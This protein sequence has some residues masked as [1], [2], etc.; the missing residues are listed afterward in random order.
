MQRGQDWWDQWFLGLAAYVSTAS[1]DPS[2]QCG[3]V[4][5]D[6]NRRVVSIGFNGFPRGV[7]DDERLADRKTKY[8]IVVHSE[9]NA[10]LF[11][12]ESVEGCVLYNWPFLPCSACASM[13]IQ[14]GVQWVVAP[15]LPERLRERWGEDIALA[16]Q[17]FRE[18]GV[19]VQTVPEAIA[20]SP[21][22]PRPSTV[23]NDGYF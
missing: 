3:A 8:K 10:L 18:A 2:T 20:W 1:K 23:S 15:A 11:A 21:S 9:R 12:R 16:T 19:T 5:V 14:A 4:I 22:D 17:L 7:K 13:I 6:S